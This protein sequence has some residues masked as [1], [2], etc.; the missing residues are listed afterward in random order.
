MK[1][2]FCSDPLNPRRGEAY[3]A[4]AGA[5]RVG[6]PFTLVDHDALARD[7]GPVKAMRQAT[8]E[9]KRTMKAACT[10]GRMPDGAWLVRHSSAALGTVEASALSREEALAKM[11]DELQYRSEWCP[12]SGVSGDSIELQVSEDPGPSRRR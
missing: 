1:F 3:Q 5:E 8:S 6:I 12:C 4:E 10:V 9:R 11:R 2:V 7:N